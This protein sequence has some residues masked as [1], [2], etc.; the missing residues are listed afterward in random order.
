MSKHPRPNA[1]ASLSYVSPTWGGPF[2][3]VRNQRGNLVLTP[4]K[5]FI[6][7]GKAILEHIKGGAR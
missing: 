7:G 1:D 4:L 2:V 3:W 5:G 6:D